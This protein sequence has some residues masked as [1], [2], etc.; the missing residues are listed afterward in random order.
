[1]KMVFILRSLSQS[2]ELRRYLSGISSTFITVS[3]K[4]TI[5]VTFIT[6]KN[7]IYT[8][9][10]IILFINSRIAVLIHRFITPH[11]RTKGVVSKSP[12]GGFG[13]LRVLF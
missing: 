3:C 13:F 6:V 12:F 5:P 4:I 1:M 11:S 10:K 2:F 9:K 8:V 7:I